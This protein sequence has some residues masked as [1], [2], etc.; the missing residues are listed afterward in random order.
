MVEASC[1]CGAVRL[2]LSEPPRDVFECNCSICRKLGVLWAYYQT[3]QVTIHAAPDATLVYSW[4][5]RKLGFHTCK[6][7]GCTTYWKALE[8]GHPRMGM[9]ARL[10]EGLGK[11]TA[12]VH[13][14]DHGGKGLFWT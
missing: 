3:S 2:E 14:L 6:T 4:G 1:H 13:H 11:T 7:C 10:V 12:R 5:D 8:P 9:N